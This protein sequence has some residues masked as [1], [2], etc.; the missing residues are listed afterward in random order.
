MLEA[1]VRKGGKQHPSWG[2]A[3]LVLVSIQRHPTVEWGR[4]ENEDVL[5]L[6]VQ[7]PSTLYRRLRYKRSDLWR[8]TCLKESNN[9]NPLTTLETF[10]KRDLNG[11]ADRVNYSS[12]EW[13]FQDNKGCQKSAKPY[14]SQ[15][16]KEKTSNIQ[17]KETP[18]LSF[19][20]VEWKSLRFHVLRSKLF[21]WWK[22]GLN[23]FCL[24]MILWKQ[25]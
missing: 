2:W 24:Q 16:C 20:F 19:S 14:Y 18:Y 17:L 15:W 13:T 21:L 8:Y 25:R 10:E 22:C 1:A 6:I 7:W 11:N 4:A 3:A 5:K 9:E 23:V 12:L